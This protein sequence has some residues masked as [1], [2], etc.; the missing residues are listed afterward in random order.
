MQ[1]AQP[2]NAPKLESTIASLQDNVISLQAQKESLQE[3]L[4]KAQGTIQWFQEQIKLNQH[5][6]FAK[7]SETSRSLT[8]S[9]FDDHESDEVT[10]TVEPI[11][12]EK[13]QVTYSRKKRTG[14]TR[15][16]DTSKI[17]KVRVFND[18]SP[19]EKICHCGCEMQKI[20]EDKS[21][22]IDHIP[23]QLKMIE[24][25]TPKYTCRS[26]ETIVAAK[27]PDSPLPKSMATTNLIADVVIRKYDE[28]LPLYRQSKIF[29]RDGII[30]PD[31][32][33]GNWVIG[34]A[35]ALF[36]LGN[37]FWQQVT[38]TKYLQAD[39]TRV[40]ILKPDKKGYMWVY[41][42]LDPGNRFVIVEFDLTRA[43]KVPENRLAN[44]AGKL[45]TDG[46]S[47]YKNLGKQADVIPLGCWDHARRKFVDSI[48][49]NNNNK[50]GIAGDCLKLINRLY[51][52]ERGIKNST[53]EQR[54][55]VRQEK[56]KPVLDKLFAIVKKINMLPKSTLA[57]AI[58]YLKNNEQ[59]LREYIE[60]GDA[61]ISNCLTENIIRPFAVGR[62]NWL[63]VGNE[64]SAN[65][66]ALLYSLIQ[67]CKINKINVRKYL[68]YVL[69]QSQAMRRGDVDPISLLPQFIDPEVLS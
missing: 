3:Q 28:H 41:Q 39:E 44:F 35:D 53:I 40:K 29:E 45:Q 49:A 63:F 57:T 1:K 36:P 22:K 25:I 54:Y 9:L 2:K 20:G 50:T 18:L 61:H 32:T 13:E 12:D 26:C 65:K 24:T 55:E 62:R 31:N 67:S 27:K 69:N 51:K 66:S 15:N 52:I 58:T 34:A 21:E 11:N 38:L 23:A 17:E 37:A 47:G 56:S 7:Q 10:E 48:K 42:G 8:L 6:Q 4:D 14:S 19:A 43:A 46:Y 64:A 33:L 68:T 5:R 59:Q 16:I 60:H 30:I